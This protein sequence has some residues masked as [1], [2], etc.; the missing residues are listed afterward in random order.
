M[1]TGTLKILS[2]HGLK[3][4]QKV[5]KICI[6]VCKILWGKKTIFLFTLLGH[7]WVKGVGQYGTLS[8]VILLMDGFL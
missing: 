5:T 8:M 6:I 7:K 3:H 2:G 1:M 4:G